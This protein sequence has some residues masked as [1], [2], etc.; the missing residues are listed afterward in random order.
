MLLNTTKYIIRISVLLLLIL[1]GFTAVYPEWLDFKDVLVSE[2]KE[3][4]QREGDEKIKQSGAHFSCASEPVVHK[5]RNNPTNDATN[6]IPRI[7][8]DGAPKVLINRDPRAFDKICEGDTLEYYIYAEN[9]DR[10]MVTYENNQQT[11]L[12]GI[13]QPVNFETPMKFTTPKGWLGNTTIKVVGFAKGEI[14]LASNKATFNI[15]KRRLNTGPD[16]SKKETA[17]KAPPS[18]KL[19]WRNEERAESFT[20]IQIINGKTLYIANN[21]NSIDSWRMKIDLKKGNMEPNSRLLLSNDNADIWIKT[22]SPSKRLE[23]ALLK[24]VSGI[25]VTEDSINGHYLIS[26][27]V[28]ASDQALPGI[29]EEMP[30]QGMYYIKGSALVAE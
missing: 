13:V 30:A 27:E 25:L 8:S 4:S 2:Y 22:L 12:H 28:F 24:N 17:S 7:T 19:K 6:N 21:P 11:F 23:P 1:L 14:R 9:V 29:T 26:L 18:F 5:S 20:R 3:K 16:K 10:I 15:I